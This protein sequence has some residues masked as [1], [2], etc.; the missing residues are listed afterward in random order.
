MSFKIIII[1]CFPSIQMIVSMIANSMAF[2]YYLLIDIRI[3]N[4]IFTYTKKSS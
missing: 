4:N 3:S 2:I 1:I